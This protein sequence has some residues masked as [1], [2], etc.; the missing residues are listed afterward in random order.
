RLGREYSVHTQR[1]PAFDPAALVEE[2]VVVPVQIDGKV[3]AKL[4]VPAGLS[5][6]EIMQFAL[7]DAKVQEHQR[8]DKV[9]AVKWIEDR[10][11]SL[12]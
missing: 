1:W 8:R 6:N 4:S 11:L 5:E 3:R 2:T 12:Y 9:Y 7:G 10:M